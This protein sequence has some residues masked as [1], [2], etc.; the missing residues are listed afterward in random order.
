[1]AGVDAL[2]DSQW[3]PESDLPPPLSLKR[4][5]TLAKAA[6]KLRNPQFEDIKVGWVRISKSTYAKK[7]VWY[8]EVHCGATTKSPP[9]D[10]AGCIPSFAIILMDG[11]DVEPRVVQK[12][13]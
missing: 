5:C 7:P 6:I 11:T 4:A 9:S 3:H 13:R 1:M 10:S 2:P 12:N 8:Y